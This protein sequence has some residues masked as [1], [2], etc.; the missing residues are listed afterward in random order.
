MVGWLRRFFLTFR[1]ARTVDESG[2][3]RPDGGW[4][5][6]TL[7]FRVVSVVVVIGSCCRLMVRRMNLGELK[8]RRY[9]D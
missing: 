7:S 5:L 9:L 8:L 4:S 1:Q 3:R 2:G 6:V